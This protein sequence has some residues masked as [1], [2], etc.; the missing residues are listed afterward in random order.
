MNK[1]MNPEII[2]LSAENIDAEHICCAIGN[3]KTSRKR[4]AE[5]KEWLRQQIPR[6]FTFKKLNVRGKVFIEYVPAEFAWK[7]VDAPGYNL[8]NCFWVSGKYKGQGYGRLLLEEA[9]KDSEGTNGLVVVTGRKKMAWLVDRKIFLKF[10]FEPC[11]QAPPYFELLVWK[12]NPDAPDPKFRDS[13]R[14]GSIDD[15]NGV[16]IMYSHQCPFH[17]DFVDIM[18]QAAREAGFKARKIRIDSLE[19]AR[20]VP[21]AQGLVGVY[22]NGKFL[23][24]EITTAKKFKQILEQHR[25]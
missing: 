13:V 21:Y 8:I 10:G 14:K 24:H 11:D 7:P 6:S 18:I 16:V 12:N 3:D 1:K 20:N 5:K 19:E 4:E 23:N 2:T 25:A 17:E 22:L 9:I 15:T